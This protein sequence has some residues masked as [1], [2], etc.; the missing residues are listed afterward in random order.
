MR[1]CGHLILPAASPLLGFFGLALNI[2]SIHSHV[3]WGFY[4]VHQ[5]STEIFKRLQTIENA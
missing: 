2:G 5:L 4:S 1:P 3:E